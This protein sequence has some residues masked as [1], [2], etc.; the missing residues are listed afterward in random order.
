MGT[1]VA[2]IVLFGV[3]FF[4]GL[5]AAYIPLLSHGWLAAWFVFSVAYIG[6]YLFLKRDL[7]ETNEPPEVAGMEDC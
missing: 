5:G 6:S 7:L 4:I 2:R 1:G 3:A